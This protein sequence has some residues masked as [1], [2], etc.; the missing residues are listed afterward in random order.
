MINFSLQK[1]FWS[2][3]NNILKECAR[4]RAE[5]EEK[6]LTAQGT[7]DMD[8]ALKL[9][10]AVERLRSEG[11]DVQMNMSAF[12][13]QFECDA[14]S[15]TSD[16]QKLASAIGMQ[17]VQEDGKYKFGH[18]LE[19]YKYVNITSTI[20]DM[21]M[22]QA[23]LK[24]SLAEIEGDPK[25][26]RDG[27]VKTDAAL[28]GKFLVLGTPVAVEGEEHC[29]LTFAAINAYAVQH[30]MDGIN[31]F[32]EAFPDTLNITF[33]SG[34]RAGMHISAYAAS[35]ICTTLGMMKRFLTEVTF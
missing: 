16:M 6:R 22:Y 31:A 3:M 29:I 17:V 18:R 10:R 2:S 21:G 30:M 28:L 27:L 32:S 25:M 34:N 33:T 4:E 1:N 9:Q 20:H 19:D 13:P 24:L 26:V 12:M 23:T 35:A 5:R 14:V 7:A 8:T 11:H 15:T